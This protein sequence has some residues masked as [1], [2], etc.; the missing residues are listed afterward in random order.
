MDYFEHLDKA[1]QQVQDIVNHFGDKLEDC[2]LDEY[3]VCYDLVQALEKVGWT[4]EY[5]LDACPYDLKRIDVTCTTEAEFQ[6]KMLGLN[7]SQV[8][9]IEE[10]DM[11]LSDEL[12]IQI[13]ELSKNNPNFIYTE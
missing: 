11:E 13:N 5:Y 3:Q 8:I 12:E 6:T 2:D 7:Q 9:A 1:P 10:R 4:C